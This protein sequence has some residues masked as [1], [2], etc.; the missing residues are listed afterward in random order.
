MKLLV[1]STKKEYG[2]AAYFLLI[3]IKSLVLIF[4]EW[5][6]AI[7]Q[8]PLSSGIFAMKKWVVLSLTSF[9]TLKHD[10]ETKTRETIFFL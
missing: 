10:C 4:S 2:L 8:S 3:L 9:G 1:S 7:C 6:W 5:F